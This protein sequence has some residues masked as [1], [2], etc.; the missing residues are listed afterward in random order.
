MNLKLEGKKIAEVHLCFPISESV[1]KSDV[2]DLAPCGSAQG[3]T[4][5]QTYLKNEY[6][7]PTCQ[8][9]PLLPASVQVSTVLTWLRNLLSRVAQPICM[10]PE[11][12]TVT[13]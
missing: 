1:C 6:A 13:S 7:P 9:H 5:G 10:T 3:M 4:T 11:V 8:N 12:T 2:A